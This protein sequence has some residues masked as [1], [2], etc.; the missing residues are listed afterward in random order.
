[1]Y[2][3]KSEIIIVCCYVYIVESPIVTSPMN[4]DTFTTN[5]QTDNTFTCN[6]TGSPMPII[7][8]FYDGAELIRVQGRPASMEDLLMNRVMLGSPVPLLNPVTGL[9]EVSRTLTL[10][11]AVDRDSGAFVCSASAAIP[12]SGMRADSVM[13]NLTVFG[14]LLIFCD[15]IIIL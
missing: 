8:F 10:F 5:E 6:A 14:K 9:Y 1:M 15:S 2:L 7:S 12:G 3:S 13:F 11:N 4:F